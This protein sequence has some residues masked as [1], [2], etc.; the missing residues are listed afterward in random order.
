LLTGA[1]LFL[2]VTGIKRANPALEVVEP[3]LARR[4]RYIYIT[5][6][7]TLPALA[8]AADALVRRWRQLAILVVALPLIGL[9]GN[10]HRL[11]TYQSEF[12]W[13][14]YRREILV[15]ARAPL[16]ARVPPATLVPI[17]HTQ[18]MTVGWLVAAARSGQLPTPTNLKPDELAT[19]SLAVALKDTYPV[20]G[21]CRWLQSPT[22]LVLRTGDRLGVKSGA[23]S[24]EYT[25]PDGGVSRP[26]SLVAPTTVTALA[27]PLSLNLAPT[28]IATTAC[29]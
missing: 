18:R 19:A 28:Q 20:F 8:V 12:P 16:A 17:D 9:P 6:A 25:S 21:A 13:R 1:L 29:S 2:I 27:G 24:V 7:M 11:G 22:T 14:T 3:A 5:G 4:S 23:I 10:F 15:L 26:R